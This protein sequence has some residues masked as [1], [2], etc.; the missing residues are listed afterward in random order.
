MFFQPHLSTNAGSFVC[1]RVARNTPSRFITNS[2]KQ[3]GIIRNRLLLHGCQ[4]SFLRL[5][6][7][8]KCHEAERLEWVCVGAG[9]LAWEPLSD[10]RVKRNPGFG[11]IWILSSVRVVC[12]AVR[13]RSSRHVLLASAQHAQQL[14]RHACQLSEKWSLINGQLSSKYLHSSLACRGEKRFLHTA[15]VDQLAGAA[16]V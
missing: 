4:I 12:C 9:S 8:V 16:R 6:V 2:A 1:T 11:R 14:G 13:A 15:S 7:F 3:R 10:H 5:R